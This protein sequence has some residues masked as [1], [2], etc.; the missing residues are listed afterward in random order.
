MSMAGPYGL[1]FG[2]VVALAHMAGPPSPEVAALLEIAL[3]IAEAELL[4]GLKTEDGASDGVQ[5]ET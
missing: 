3:P 4:K 2:A 5:G 1:D